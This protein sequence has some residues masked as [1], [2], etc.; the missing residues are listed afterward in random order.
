MLDDK[1]EKHIFVGYYACSKGYK[2]DSLVTKKTMVSRDVM[3]DEEALW[4]W[5]D[6]L[7]DYSDSEPLNYDEALEDDK[8][9]ILMYEEIKVIK[10]NNKLEL[11]ALPSG[12]SNRSRLAVKRCIY[13]NV[14]ASQRPREEL[15]AHILASKVR[16]AMALGHLHKIGIFAFRCRLQHHGASWLEAPIT[17]H[18]IFALLCLG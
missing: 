17:K 10:K 7:E 9:K 18:P 15:G 1:S 16:S 5:N 3:F 8:W 6:D 12:R 2:F 11:S 13:E 14:Q 4:S